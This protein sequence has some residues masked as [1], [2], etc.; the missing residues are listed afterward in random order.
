MA[1][2]N[3]FNHLFKKYHIIYNTYKCQKCNVVVYNQ[4]NLWKTYCYDIGKTL[5]ITCDEYIIKGII[6]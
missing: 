2:K 1:N 4:N 6:E 5:N 3:R